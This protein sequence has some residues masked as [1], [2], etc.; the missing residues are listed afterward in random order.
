MRPAKNKRTLKKMLTTSQLKHFHC[1]FRHY[2][3][4]APQWYM[5]TKEAAPAV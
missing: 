2:S 4:Q 1:N 3:P 5:S